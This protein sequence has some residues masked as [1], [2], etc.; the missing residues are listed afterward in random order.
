M[1]EETKN[2]KKIVVLGGGFGGLFFCKAF[3][4]DAFDGQA[5]RA[6]LR[7]RFGLGALQA[8]HLV[9]QY[10]RDAE[11]LLAAAPAEHRRP[12]GTS[13][14]SWAEIPWSMRTEC[15]ITLCDLLEHRVRMALFAV[16]QGLPELP[17]IAELAG[18]AVGWSE[19]RI[20]RETTAYRDAVKRRYQIAA[21][22]DR[23]ARAA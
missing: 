4:D 20:A 7:E 15:A 11:A 23:G 2:R 14:F 10:G 19:E 12:I 13:R 5:L 16:G 8:R 3:R 17:A 18:H 1:P 21:H 22:R 6:S 9:Q